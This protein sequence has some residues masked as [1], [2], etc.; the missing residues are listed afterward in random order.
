MSAGRGVVWTSSVHITC[1][2]LR[3]G[4]GDGFSL[5][6]HHYAWDIGDRER[7]CRHACVGV[8]FISPGII[9]T[10]AYDRAREIY[11]NVI[12]FAERSANERTKDEVS[13][14]V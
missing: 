5:Y 1:M 6:T 14:P 4:K 2:R 11:H 9:Y 7:G 12:V 3:G 8:L 10:G 13:L